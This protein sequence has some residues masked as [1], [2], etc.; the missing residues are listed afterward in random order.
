MQSDWFFEN[1]TL[2]QNGQ[3]IYW[4]H[5]G[6]AIVTIVVLNHPAHSLVILNKNILE[7]L[8]DTSDQIGCLVSA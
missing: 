3:H 7:Y 6:Y 5:I 1:Q 2:F 4:D 8:Q